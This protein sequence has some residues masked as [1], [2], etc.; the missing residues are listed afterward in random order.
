MPTIAQSKSWGF[1]CHR[2]HLTLINYLTAQVYIFVHR[3]KRPLN[4]NISIAIKFK[5]HKQISERAGSKSALFFMVSAFAVSGL[6]EVL[7]KYLVEWNSSIKTVSKLI[8]C[9]KYFDSPCPLNPSLYP[10]SDLD[11]VSIHLFPTHQVKSTPPLTHSQN[12]YNVNVT[13][14]KFYDLN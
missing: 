13:L 8:E 6:Q 5:V 10:L 9:N 4:V 1:Y 2:L 7:N 11:H 12:H 14:Y 3:G